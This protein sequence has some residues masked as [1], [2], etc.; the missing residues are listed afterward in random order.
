MR[1]SSRWEKGWVK[2]K[3]PDNIITFS[4]KGGRII[5]FEI[6]QVMLTNLLK[7]AKHNFSVIHPK[8]YRYFKWNFRS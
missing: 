7:K 3:T 6:A 1:D 4:I 2:E 8:V 5:N